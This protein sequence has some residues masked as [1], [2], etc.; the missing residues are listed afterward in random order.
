LNSYRHHISGVFEQKFNA[1]LVKDDLI[2]KG[3]LDSQISITKHLTYT[4]G[5]DPIPQ[6]DNLSERLLVMSCIG[7]ISGIFLACLIELALVI[8]DQSLLHSR[9]GVS[10]MWLLCLGII[11]G[12]LTGMLVGVVMGDSQT[13]NH[14]PSKPPARGFQWIHMLMGNKKVML[15]VMTYS[16]EQT[17][18]VV[19]VMHHSAHDYCDLKILPS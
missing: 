11:I 16:I 2:K 1:R 19:E 9:W 3:I 8:M 12:T 15:S 18:I 7:A 17:A 14:Q 10:T 6:P 13:N 5:S 4:F